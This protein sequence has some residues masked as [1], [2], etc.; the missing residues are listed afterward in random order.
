M[1]ISIEL[2]YEKKS[3]FARVPFTNN[4]PVAMFVTAYARLCLYD[5]IEEVDRCGALPLYCDTDSV[6]YVKK[7]GRE[8]NLIY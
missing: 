2:L 8:G 6:F 1:S 5:R 4:L 7:I 3:E